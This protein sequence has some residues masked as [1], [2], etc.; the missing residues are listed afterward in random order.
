MGAP[1]IDRLEQ[2][3]FING[4]FKYFQ[5]GTNIA[6]PGGI[7]YTTADRWRIGFNAPL[8]NP[9]SFQSGTIPSGGIAKHSLTLQVDVAGTG[10][11][12][13][14]QQRIESIFARNL[15]KAGKL[16]LAVQVAT[17]SASQCDLDLRYASTEDNFSTLVPIITQPFSIIP[18]GAGGSVFATLK[19]EDLV[20]PSGVLNG[21]QLQIRFY[22]FTINGAGKVHRIYQP[23]LNAGSV[24][25]DFN[26][27]SRN[28]V[29]E[30][31]LCQRYFE[32][33]EDIN[34]SSA[35]AATKLFKIA[36]SNAEGDN[37]EAF[38]VRKR[39]V[40]IVTILGGTSNISTGSIT[41]VSEARFA[42]NFNTPG[43]NNNYEFHYRADAEL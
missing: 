27:A 30:L 29:E 42:W 5:R 11:D 28:L 15:V 4:A 9:V 38:K 39:V 12:V 19:I 23:M 16:S 25:L 7:A 2:N 26:H 8:T 37:D 35:A 21:L 17:D 24:A 6:I 31:I 41:R 36:A 3:Y 34:D 22:N 32:K 20:V 18:D 13:Q 1:R 10:G 14:T 33:S 40:P 43:G